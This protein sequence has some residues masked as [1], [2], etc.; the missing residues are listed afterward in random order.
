MNISQPTRFQL[1][2]GAPGDVLCSLG[3]C[4]KWPEFTGHFVYYGRDASVPDFIRAQSF[5]RELRVV[6][7]SDGHEY[8]WSIQALCIHPRNH[9]QRREFLQTIAER[10]GVDNL[11]EFQVHMEMKHVWPN[12]WWKSTDLPQYAKDWARETILKNGKPNILIHPY[13]FQSNSLARHWPHWETTLKWFSEQRQWNCYLTGCGWQWK[14]G[15]GHMVNLLGRTPTNNHVLGLQQLA[16]LTIGTS[17]NLSHYATVIDRPMVTCLNIAVQ[18]PGAYFRR[19]YEF[20]GATII[21]FH[22]PFKKLRD[23]VTN[24][25][26]KHPGKP[27]INEIANAHPL[28]GRVVAPAEKIPIPVVVAAGLE[29]VEPNQG[30]AVPNGGVVQECQQ[31]G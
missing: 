15:T 17:C 25:L 1:I 10:A 28:D 16:D 7:P 8:G 3:Y 24:H 2:H 26:S 27:R 22:E 4:I 5:C 21:G 11:A 31:A 23:A 12:V 13:S 30:N 19:Q 6:A 20:G 14:A 9:P 29:A 18:N